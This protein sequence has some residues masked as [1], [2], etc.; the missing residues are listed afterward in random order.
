MRKDQMRMV[1]M[2]EFKNTFPV[3]D[4]PVRVVRAR[5]EVRVIGVWTPEKERLNGQATKEV[6]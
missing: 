1:T 5:G 3:L 4:E 2:R 6:E